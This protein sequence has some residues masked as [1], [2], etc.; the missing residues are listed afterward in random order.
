MILSPAHV[1]LRDV[2]ADLYSTTADL[3]TMVASAGLDPIAIQYT[4]N[5]VN[6]W[7]SAV[8]EA[9]KQSRVERLIEVA[10]RRF[11]DYPPLRAASDGHQRSLIATDLDS[12]RRAAHNMGHAHKRYT[13]D[14]EEILERFDLELQVSEFTRRLSRISGGGV[15][16]FATTGD[17]SIINDYM[18]PRVLTY[19]E[20]D[21]ARTVVAHQAWLGVGRQGQLEMS[22]EWEGADGDTNG[23]IDCL[24]I[25]AGETGIDR[26]VAVWNEDLAT[27][28]MEGYA[29]T[30]LS[31]CQQRLQDSLERNGLLF[32][33]VWI[34]LQND[35]PTRSPLCIVPPVDTLPVAFVKRWFERQLNDNYK[36]PIDSADIAAAMARL[37]AKLRANQGRSRGVYAAMREI[38]RD[39]Q[40][41]RV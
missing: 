7:Q 40:R 12:R 8:E 38:I 11:P 21:Q 37:D 2:L 29:L 10:K 26:L 16:P 25:L 33:V 27:T 41:G 31:E 18:L 39:L 3:R 19:L 13:I 32:V 28:E 15:V 22:L 34:S 14:H 23:P 6:E 17:R 20:E 5:I 35:Q 4:G 9:V 36:D 1:Q 24:L 30:F